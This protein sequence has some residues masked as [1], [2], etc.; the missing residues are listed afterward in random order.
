[1]AIGDISF[2]RQ[3]KV[4]V[5]VESVAGTLVEPVDADMILSTSIPVIKQERETFD[6]KQITDTRSKLAPIAGRYLAGSWSFSSYIKPSGSLGTAPPEDVLLTGLIG[7]KTVDAGVDV[8]YTLASAVPPSYSIWFKD[9]HTV[10]MCSGASVDKGT[11][12]IDGKN[13][14]EIDWSGGFMKLL[15][16]GTSTLGAAITD[17]TSTTVTP[18]DI[19]FYNEGSIFTIGTERMKVVTVGASTLTVTRGYGST[20]PATHL[21]STAM[22]PWLPTG[23]DSGNIVHGRLGICTLGG[24]DYMVLSTQVT[25]T[26]GIKYYEEEK[27][28]Q[29]Y[30]TEYGVPSARNVEATA[31]VY[32]RKA[33]VQRFAD[34]LNFDS[35]ALVIPIGS[36]AGK[37][38]QL[39]LPQCKTKAPD[40]SGDAERQMAMVFLPYAT[41]SSASDEINIVYK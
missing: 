18:V 36:I 23:T 8:T 27:N 5:K 32:F 38:V 33:E 10:Y 1:M 16:T 24:A 20:T 15:W 6:D 9:G 3:S 7:T 28:G 37:V 22:T 34:A 39:N 21:I 11:F 17:T 13:P 14:G 19:D 35:V 40:I 4:F 31:T 2:G 26:N 29:D 41:T 30:A 25:I 12:K